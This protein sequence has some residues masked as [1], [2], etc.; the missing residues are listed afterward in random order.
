L[1]SVTPGSLLRSGTARKEL[2]NDKLG[3]DKWVKNLADLI[4][5]YPGGDSLTIALYGQWGSGKT[6]L[7]N[8]VIGALQQPGHEN[9]VVGRF[10][11]WNFSQQDKVYSAFF[12]TISRLLRKADKSD[13][14]RKLS[15]ALDALSVATAPAA[16][17]N[18]GFV[19]SGVK[20]LADM[21][22]DYADSLGDIERVKDDI[23]ATLKRSEKRLVIVIDDIDRLTEGEVRQ[24]FQLVKSVADFENVVYLLAFDHN[25]VAKALD[26]ITGNEG[27]AFL[28]KITNVV[29]RVPPLTRRQVRQL[30]LADLQ[31]YADRQREYPWNA[32]RLRRVIEVALK[33]FKTLRQMERFGN[34]LTATEGL[35]ATDF[36]FTDHIALSMLQTL[37]P[38]LFDFVGSHPELFVD[39]IENRFARTNERDKL[40]KEEVNAALSALRNLPEEAAREL[41]GA[42]F[43]KIDRLFSRYGSS[44]EWGTAEWRTQGRACASF[45]TFSRYF[46]FAVDES[47]L[48]ASD[49]DALWNAARNVDDLETYLRSLTGEKLFSVYEFLADIDATAF[50]P[51]LLRNIITATI[52]IGDEFAVLPGFDDIFRGPMLQAE[53]ALIV[54][55]RALPQDARFELVLEAFRRPP[56]SVQMPSEV[57]FSFAKLKDGMFTDEQIQELQRVCR[58]LYEASW[59]RGEFVTHRRFLGMLPDWIGRD[60]PGAEV[61]AKIRTTLENDDAKFLQLLGR[62]E[63][64]QFDRFEPDRFNTKYLSQIYTLEEIQARLE[65]IRDNHEHAAQ[66]ENIEELIAEVQRQ[67]QERDAPPV[68]EPF[69][70]VPPQTPPL[71]DLPIVE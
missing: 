19:A 28:E 58:Q 3:R 42:V 1:A 64:V 10:N 49:R 30:L 66:R 43:P 65:G 62:Y 71:D 35:T 4:T 13:R 45:T 57:A 48:S 36:D 52:D 11:P 18:F 32:E 17:A 40:D 68:P 51:A 67:I 20:T 27:H 69:L 7:L 53:R 26:A 16:L 44:T 63:N 9:I 24:V 2:A 54:L 31:G 41:L 33:G 23:S 5:A 59:E 14:A 46:V 47:E 39:D 25:M 15:K 60:E 38:T 22:K 34:V 29:L 37:E 61:V 12:A 55:L 50:E 70:P 21:T 6:T 8:F 56:K